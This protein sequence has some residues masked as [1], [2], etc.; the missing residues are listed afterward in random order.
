MSAT[1]KVISPSH[2]VWVQRAVD[3]FAS[4]LGGVWTA[5]DL[6]LECPYLPVP[7]G[8]IQ[9]PLGPGMWAG[10]GSIG[11]LSRSAVSGVPTC[12]VSL[13]GFGSSELRA[14]IIEVGAPTKNL[15]CLVPEEFCPC[16]S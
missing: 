1:L 8:P 9:F 7:R 13:K 4:G 2:G 5:G 12:P 6:P 15:K 14:W 10:V 16:V 11:G 3:Q